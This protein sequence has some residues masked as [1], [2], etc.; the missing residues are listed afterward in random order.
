MRYGKP[1]S[2]Q[3]VPSLHFLS[4]IH[5]CALE[6]TNTCTASRAKPYVVEQRGWAAN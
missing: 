3:I 6:K 5:V 1:F 4:T 2:V